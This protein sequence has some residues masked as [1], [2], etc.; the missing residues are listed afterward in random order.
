MEFY[1]GDNHLTMEPRRKLNP[2]YARR[3]MKSLGI[4]PE[5]IRSA[6]SLLESQEQTPP[7]KNDHVHIDT[8]FKTLA[9]ISYERIHRNV[10]TTPKAQRKWETKLRRNKMDWS[11]VRLNQTD[12]ARLTQRLYLMVMR[13]EVKL[14]TIRE[15]HKDWKK[16]KFPV[17][18]GG[19]HITFFAHSPLPCITDDPNESGRVTIY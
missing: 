16:G 17:P 10:A 3:C 12:I 8:W 13:K 18:N 11:D 6:V 14:G 19:R 7:P 9:G 4:D 2:T 1:N 5:I 15:Q